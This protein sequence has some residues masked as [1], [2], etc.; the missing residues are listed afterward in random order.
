MITLY[1]Q[2]YYF[3]YAFRTKS[4]LTSG[5]YANRGQQSTDAVVLKY[6]YVHI[7]I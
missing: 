6:S 5:V 7:S 2:V 1:T 4:V 3:V